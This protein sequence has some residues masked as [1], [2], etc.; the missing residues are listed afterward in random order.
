VAP[1]AGGLS[2]VY[3][4]AAEQ[5]ESGPGLW[6]QVPA[7]AYFGP[8]LQ[9]AVGYRGQIVFNPSKPD[10]TPRKLMDV[11]RPASLG[12]APAVPLDLG[13]GLAY[14]DYHAAIGGRDTAT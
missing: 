10:G 11:S 4:N 14:G 7:S 5:P 12:W 9:A 13:I 3:A 1:V 6:V 8:K 2:V